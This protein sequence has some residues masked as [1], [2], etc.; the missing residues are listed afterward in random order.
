MQSRYFIFDMMIVRWMLWLQDLYLKP[1]NKKLKEL[2]EEGMGSNITFKIEEGMSFI[3]TTGSSNIEELGKAP[4]KYK[5][6]F[7]DARIIIVYNNGCFEC[8]YELEDYGITEYAFSVEGKEF[9]LTSDSENEE[10]IRKCVMQI[11]A[12]N[13]DNM[14]WGR[15]LKEYLEEEGIEYEEE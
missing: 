12:S 5:I 8:Y 1:N 4:E 10:D 2:E 13:I 15:I 6:E 3:A 9:G 7:P 14:Y 11:L